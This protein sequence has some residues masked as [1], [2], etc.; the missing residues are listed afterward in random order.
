MSLKRIHPVQDFTDSNQYLTERP[1]DESLSEF[2]F[3]RKQVKR[4]Y[5]DCEEIDNE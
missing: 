3:V 1:Y 2:E 5:R 4:D